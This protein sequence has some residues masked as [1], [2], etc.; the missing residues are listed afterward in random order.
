[1][2]HG[3]KQWAG[4]SAS[5][6]RNQ[7]NGIL[8]G[9]S[10]YS[11]RIGRWVKGR[12]RDQEADDHLRN[13]NRSGVYRM[14]DADKV[15]EL[16]VEQFNKDLNRFRPYLRRA[17]RKYS[18]D[19]NQVDDWVQNAFMYFWKKKTPTKHW[20]RKAVWMAMDELRTRSKSRM[21]VQ[22]KRLSIKNRIV[23]SANADRVVWNDDSVLRFEDLITSR[24]LFL[25]P[26]EKELLRQRYLLNRT[27]Q[28]IALKLGVRE[29]NIS[30]RMTE[31]KKKIKE[32]LTTG[33]QS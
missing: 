29:S 24:T 10:A 14:Q 23:T 28:E 25:W 17:L 31:I 12:P 16:S 11:H 33:G 22:G 7:D 13:R 6:E 4:E 1:M 5:K 20:L 9:I 21:L 3:T 2:N 18:A 26:D 15:E 27:Q 8:D 32:Q 30:I 19:P